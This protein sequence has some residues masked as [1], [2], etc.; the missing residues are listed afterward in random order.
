MTK[1][2]LTYQNERKLSPQLKEETKEISV[3]LL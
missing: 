3:H 1:E 2:K